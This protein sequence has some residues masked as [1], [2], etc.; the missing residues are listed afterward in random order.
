MNIDIAEIRV[1]HVMLQ[2]TA[3]WLDF[4]RGVQREE[5]KNVGMEF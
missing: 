2:A 3:P 4:G 5:G 1:Q